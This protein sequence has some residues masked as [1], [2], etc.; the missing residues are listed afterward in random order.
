M[1]RNQLFAG[2]CAVLGGVAILRASPAAQA[3]AP[4]GGRLIANN[5]PKLAP[6]AK[7]LGP[8]SPSTTIDL[9]IWLNLHNRSELDSLARELYDPSSPNYRNWLGLKD[10]MARSR[11]RGRRKDG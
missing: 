7:N 10:F 6:A 11:P 9:G 3:A 4:G 1:T 8:A 2:L 5:T